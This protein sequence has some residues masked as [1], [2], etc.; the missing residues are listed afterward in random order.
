MNETIANNAPRGVPSVLRRYRWALVLAAILL[1]GLLVL[2]L[3][4]SLIAWQAGKWITGH[5]GESFSV[6]NV[7]FNPFKMVLV[8]EDVHI[9]HQGGESLVLPRLELDAAW[10]GLLDKHLT[11]TSFAISGLALQVDQQSADQAHVGGILLRSLQGDAA[12]PESDERPW[13]LAL[14]ELTIEDTRID[15]R[16]A[17]L[18][19]QAEVD[20]LRLSGLDT[21]QPTHQAMLELA[22]KLSGAPVRVAGQVRPV[23]DTLGFDGELDVEGLDLAPFAAYLPESVLAMQGRLDTAGKLRVDRTGPDLGVAHQGS[24]QLAKP[25]FADQTQRVQADAV[26]WQGSLDF[27]QTAP[28]RLTLDLD[29]H[30]SGTGLASSPPAPDAPQARS[31]AVAWQGTLR[32][33][34]QTPADLALA[35]DGSLD[36]TALAATLP[37]ADALQLRTGSLRWQGKLTVAQQEPSGLAID[38]DGSLDGAGLGTDL[39]GQSLQVRSDKLTWNGTGHL[40]LDGAAPRYSLSGSAGLGASRVTRDG[41][42][43][44]GLALQ[45]LDAGQLMLNEQ[46]EL[47]LATLDLRQL[48]AAEGAADSAPLASI[49]RINVTALRLQGPARAQ[50]DSVTV[51]GLKLADTAADSA[52][53]LYVSEHLELH[54]IDWTQAEALRVDTIRHNGV[55]TLVRHDADGAWNIPAFA[56]RLG[57]LA[58]QAPDTLTDDT[59]TTADAAAAAP[60]PATTSPAVVI[61]SYELGGDNRFDFEDLGSDPAYKSGLQV[62]EATIKNINSGDPTAI[63]T[64]HA[65]LAVDGG[66]AVAIEGTLVPGATRLTADLKADISA[67][68]MPPLSSYSGSAIGYLLDSGEM[69]A[70]IQFK[71]TDGKVDG[72]NKLVIRQLQVSELDDATVKKLGGEKIG[73][74]ETGLSMLR[75]KNNTITL[76]VPLSGD[77][78][79]LKVDPSDIIN[80]AIGSALKT[81]AKTYLAAALFPFGTLLVVADAATSAAGSASLTPVTF[82]PASSA[83]GEQTAYL[84]K[85]AVVLNDRPE[86]NV[87]VCALATDSDR[88]ALLAGLRAELA[89]QAAEKSD[90]AGKGAEPETVPAVEPSVS[91]EALLAL[92]RQRADAI[93]RYL[94]DGKGIGDERLVSCREKIDPQAKAA[95]R[96]E[97]RL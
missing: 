60:A 55:T 86:M 97:L 93:N 29:G 90:K 22:A 64:L 44:L 3:L 72:S 34:R 26:Q 77:I 80:Q 68:P 38:L 17:Q 51:D 71:A 83:L 53:N 92:A 62:T 65:K 66:G 18:A 96:V 15:Y 57:G 23:G 27:K 47:T 10:Q 89:R 33:S 94:V 67:L 54:A 5:G 50:I 6:A 88:E 12:E 41:V 46:L 87:R 95:P 74:L 8:L 43:G 20:S 25:A 76:N 2:A 35:V 85:I 79:D 31:D 81:G 40:A 16:D 49:D 63:G 11:I 32:L 59:A 42:P 21:L 48:S 4:P 82:A 37:G 56:E 84:D 61:G 91:D 73:S 36:G 13:S 24:L 70:D 75:D 58:W 14:G 52:R 19:L 28:D 78:D 39:P 7:D 30:L 45:G 69:N 1:L 9:R